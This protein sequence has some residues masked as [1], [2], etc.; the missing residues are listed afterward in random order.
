MSKSL[1]EK[2]VSAKNLVD[3]W[4]AILEDHG[5][6]YDDMIVVFRLAKKRADF[7]IEKESV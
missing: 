2:S 5:Y 1:L 3:R 4:V 7:L 6:T